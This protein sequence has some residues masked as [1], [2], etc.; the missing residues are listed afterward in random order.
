MNLCVSN[1]AWSGLGTNQSHQRDELVRNGISL[2]ELAPALTWLNPNKVTSKENGEVREFW[3]SL[4]I[5][6]NALQSLFFGRPD[7][8]LFED[9]SSRRAMSEYLVTLANSAAEIGASVLV[10][11]SPKN[12]IKGEMSKAEADLIAFDFFGELSSEIDDLDVVIAIEPNPPLYF[13]DYLISAQEVLD[14]VKELNCGNIRMNFDLACSVLANEDPSDMLQ[15][16]SEF[17]AHI[18]VS[19][20]NLGP[21]SELRMPHKKFAQTIQQNRKILQGATVSMEMRDPT[22]HTNLVSES[23]SIFRDVYDD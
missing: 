17:V 12:R 11:G 5:E 4:G 1:I 2:V 7:L 19:E 3:G 15:E 13:A 23:I 10:F 9:K 21:I 16:A 18:H 8:Q 14:F 20:P 22:P 6:V